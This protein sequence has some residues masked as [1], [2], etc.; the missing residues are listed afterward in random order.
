[1]R[2]DPPRFTRNYFTTGVLIHHPVFDAVGA[3]L[4]DIARLV[5]EA[6][7]M[8]APYER[9]DL[10][11]AC[12]KIRADT[13]LLP[14]GSRFVAV[15]DQTYG[16]LRLSGRLMDP[17][18]LRQVFSIAHELAAAAEPNTISPAVLHALGVTLRASHADCRPLVLGAADPIPPELADLPRVVAPGSKG[19]NVRRGNAEFEVERV[20]YSP[21][22]QSLAYVG[23]HLTGRQVEGQTETIRADDLVE[24][25]G[26]ST[27]GYY[28]YDTGEV[29]T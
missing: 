12:D 29:Q 10:D 22:F 26:E 13:M 7:L 5:F 4:E 17:A 2:Y 21:R 14:T 16:S 27:M 8:A 9:Q 28:D 20:I 18:L 23:R 24:I 1:V 11:G 25:P 15:H 6:L 19:L 3:D